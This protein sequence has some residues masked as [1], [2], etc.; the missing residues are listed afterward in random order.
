MHFDC[1]GVFGSASDECL[2]NAI[3]IRRQWEE[4]GE[5][6]VSKLSLKA[7]AK[8]SALYYDPNEVK[9]TAFAEQLGH[10]AI[11]GEGVPP[12]E[13]REVAATGA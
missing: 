9:T 6:V 7:R 12:Q 5:G 3:S 4:V 11:E 10:A 13:K 8:Y 2:Q 1:S